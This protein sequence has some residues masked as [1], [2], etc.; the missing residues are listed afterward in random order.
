MIYA[1]N[2]VALPGRPPP[3][4]PLALDIRHTCLQQQD[5]IPLF[6]P[7]MPWYHRARLRVDESIK[8]WETP[9]NPL[10]T[11]SSPLLR[12]LQPYDPAHGAVTRRQNRHHHRRGIGSVY[13]SNACFQIA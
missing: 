1:A 9:S 10:G 8:V 7:C 13:S 3:V 12:S 6:Q 11:R 5:L 2:N 4:G